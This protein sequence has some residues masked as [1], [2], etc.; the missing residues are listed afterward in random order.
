M[1]HTGQPW[2]PG[3]DRSAPRPAPRPEAE[4]SLEFRP[5]RTPCPRPGPPSLPPR[6]GRPAAARPA[7][8]GLG[9]ARRRPTELGAREPLRSGGAGG[10]H[11][12]RDGDPAPTPAP[13]PQSP[14]RPGWVQAA[15]GCR[16]ARS[17]HGRPGSPPPVPGRTAAALGRRPQPEA[18][19]GGPVS[20]SSKS[21]AG[22]SSRDLRGRLHITHNSPSLLPLSLSQEH[23]MVSGCAMG[24]VGPRSG[25]YP[26]PSSSARGCA[27]LP[28]PSRARGA[29]RGPAG[30][31]QAGCPGGCRECGQ[32]GP[33]GVC[34]AAVRGSPHPGGRPRGLGCRFRARRAP[35]S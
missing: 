3:P 8:T 23:K 34:S 20:L 24:S 13:G 35:G 5:R 9:P 7:Q 29:P 6:A 4:A 22:A 1:G 16:R 32:E 12:R 27:G 28:P 21:R 26:R 17:P 14:G 2:A 10:S 25:F 15:A 11:L 18:V 33:G 31:P 30:R 19:E